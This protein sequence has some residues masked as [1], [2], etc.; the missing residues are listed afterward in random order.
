MKAI[1]YLA[2]VLGSTLGAL[3]E[4]SSP[5]PGGSEPAGGLAD[6][7]LKPSE[8]GQLVKRT[9]KLLLNDQANPS[10]FPEEKRGEFRTNLLYSISRD[11][12]IELGY[13]DVSRNR[14][15]S[16]RIN[17]CESEVEADRQWSARHKREEFSWATIDGAE[18]GYTVRGRVLP[19][20][21]KLGADS[22]QLKVGKYL[23]QVSPASAKREDP[24]FRLAWEQAQK[25][26][27]RSEPGGAAPNRSQPSAPE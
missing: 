14:A 8:T 23:I 19:E 16:V 21:K 24:G 6:A 10:A 11:A 20:G 22:V 15:F 5:R 1:L 25:I 7:A 9:I 18:V 2:C 27:N 13:E 3:A 12:R 4:E 26:K 17:R